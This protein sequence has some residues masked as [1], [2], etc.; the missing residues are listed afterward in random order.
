MAV[1]RTAQGHGAVEP[2]L[3]GGSAVFLSSVVTDASPTTCGSATRIPGRNPRL[4]RRADT[5]FTFI[6]S[7]TV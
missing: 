2:L 7:H 6:T 4:L 5:V 1:F 3:D